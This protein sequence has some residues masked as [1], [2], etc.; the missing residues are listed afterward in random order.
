[1]TIESI[2]HVNLLEISLRRSG[3]TTIYRSLRTHPEIDGPSEPFSMHTRNAIEGGLD[4]TDPFSPVNYPN[5]SEDITQYWE[6]MNGLYPAETWFFRH[7]LA[8]YQ[9]ESP[10]LPKVRLCKETFIPFQIGQILN[11]LPE[12]LHILDLR[13]DPRAIIESYKANNLFYRWNIPQLYSQ[14]KEAVMSNEELKSRYEQL[15]N[16]DENKSTW[17]ELLTRKIILFRRELDRNLINV[18]R[19]MNLDFEK[20][21]SEL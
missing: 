10:F 2:S 3:S 12:D 5:N 20:N 9:S 6:E 17:T 21:F 8:F 15:I 7:I 18:P 1:M 11:S 16:I 14:V 4:T 13:R 19:K